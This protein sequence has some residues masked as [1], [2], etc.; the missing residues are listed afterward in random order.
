LWANDDCP[1]SGQSALTVLVNL[2]TIAAIVSWPKAIDV[3]LD[4]S[5]KRILLLAVS[6]GGLLFWLLGSYVPALSAVLPQTTWGSATQI[7]FARLAAAALALFCV[8]QLWLAADTARWFRSR[9][10]SALHHVLA[11]FRLKPGPELFWT[12]LPLAGTLT[13]ALLLR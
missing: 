4:L 9:E 10:G 12:V 6:V 5:V 3:R 2:A 13:L 8:L 1:S 11:E 7:L